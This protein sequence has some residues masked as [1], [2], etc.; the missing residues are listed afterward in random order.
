M[1]TLKIAQFLSKSVFYKLE[2][3]TKSKK[4]IKYNNIK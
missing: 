3:M 4:E 1:I 2:L